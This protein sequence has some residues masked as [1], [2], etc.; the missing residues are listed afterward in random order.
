MLAR[1]HP[2]PL[3]IPSPDNMRLIP[4]R[5]LF[6]LLFIS[7]LVAAKDFESK[8]TRCLNA[9]TSTGNTTGGVD[10]HGHATTDLDAMVGL[11]YQTCLSECGSSPDSFNWRQFTQSFFTWLVPWL[12]LTSQL[13][14]GSDDH[15]N[16]F[17]SG[18]LPSPFITDST[19]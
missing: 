1:F 7:S 9:K 17:M 4:S 3:L 12:A 14:F 18:Q 13:P 6:P 15:V 5:I 11:T 10:R 19:G 2:I 16:N 8:F